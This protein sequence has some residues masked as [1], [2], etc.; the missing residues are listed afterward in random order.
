MN[1]NARARTWT[2]TQTGTVVSA[3]A[4]GAVLLG[5]VL[6]RTGKWLRESFSFSFVLNEMGGVEIGFDLGLLRQMAVKLGVSLFL[7]RVKTV[8]RRGICRLECMTFR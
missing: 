8:R 7:M 1:N 5:F 2:R 6:N 3:G 4:C